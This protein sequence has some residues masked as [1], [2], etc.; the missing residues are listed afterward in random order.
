MHPFKAQLVQALQPDD[1]ASRIAFA[2]RYLGKCAA[3]PLFSAKVLFSDEALFSREVIF[4]THNPHT[5]VEEN[6]CAIRCHAA[7]T[8]F[9]VT[10][11]AGIIAHRTLLVTVSSNRT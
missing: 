11:W 8:R 2:S 5:W 10:V 7:Q 6:P 1:Y 4:N 9:S 3:D